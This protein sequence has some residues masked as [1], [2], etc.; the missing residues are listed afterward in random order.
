MTEDHLTYPKT[1]YGASKLAGECYARA[2]FDTHGFPTVVVRPFNTFGPRCHHEGDSGEVIPKFL[3]RCLA[4]R[5]MIV[6]GDGSQTRDFLYVSDTARGII[7][8]GLADGTV[9]QTINLGSGREYAIN[10]L[11]QQVAAVCGAGAR[12][13]VEHTDPRPGDVLRLCADSSRAKKLFGFEPRVSLREGLEQLRDWYFGLG[14]SPQEL[15]R[16]EV[17][18]N[19]ESTG[20]VQAAAAVGRRGEAARG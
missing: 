2:F 20:G 14:Q 5:P 13:A 8:A 4:G 3:L 9:G 10:D 19:W 7:E 6:L 1:V 11:A 12:A 17:V 16:Q 18:R 15:L